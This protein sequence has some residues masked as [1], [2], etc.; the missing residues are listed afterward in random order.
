MPVTERYQVDW[1]A[2]IVLIAMVLL[3]IFIVIIAIYFFNLMNLKP[4]S[5]SESTF[6]FWTSIVLGVIF[7]IIT[8]FAMYRIFTHKVIVYEEPR[9]A[10]AVR[11]TT[12]AT[13]P[14]V[15]APPPTQIRIAPAVTAPPS[16]VSLSF[17][18]VP[19]TRTQRTALNQ[20]L[21]SLGES[22]SQ[23]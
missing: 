13:A 14:V 10:P 18:D 6:L 8:I 9:V 20:E 16:D 19:V 11:T 4:P 22:I 1:F 12:I 5:R 2:I 7:L 3:L 23:P 17:S 15:T 21:I